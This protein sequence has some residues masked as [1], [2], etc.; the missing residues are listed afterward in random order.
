MHMIVRTGVALIAAWGFVA[1]AQNLVDN[2]R[3]SSIPEHIVPTSTA[4]A[5]LLGVD[6]ALRPGAAASWRGIATTAESALIAIAIAIVPMLLRRARNGRRLFLRRALALLASSPSSRSSSEPWLRLFAIA[7]L[8]GLIVFAPVQI[9]ERASARRFI[10]ETYAPLVAGESGQLRTMIEDTLHNE[11]TRTDLST[12]L[13]DDYRHMNLDDLAY[14][15]WLR[16]DLSKW[17]VPGGDHDRRRVHAHHHQPLRRRPAAVHRARQRQ[18][19]ARCCR[20][21]RSRAC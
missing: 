21:A 2:S 3:I 17:R 16:S 14:A 13:P 1:L 11:F 9:F 7:L 18:R 5:L 8:A 19:R 6:A 20:S 15:L 10:A 4:Q 12:I